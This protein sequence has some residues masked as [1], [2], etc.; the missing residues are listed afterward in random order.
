M[1]MPGGFG[2]RSSCC[3]ANSAKLEEKLPEF[4]HM[5]E[6]GQQAR[7]NGDLPPATFVVMETS[8]QAR[9]SEHYDLETA[10]W[11]DTL[12]LHTLFG[13]AILAAATHRTVIGR[14]T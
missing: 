1:T 13:H 2:R 6:V 7:A 14:T 5:A 8:L 10:L 11:S 9:E 4:R 3:G 12:A